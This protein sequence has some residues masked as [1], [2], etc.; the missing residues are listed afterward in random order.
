LE[1]LGTRS[2]A[3]PEQAPSGKIG[4]TRPVAVTEHPLA[5]SSARQKYADST[6]FDEVNKDVFRT[7]AEIAFFA[8]VLPGRSRPDSYWEDTQCDILKPRTHHDVLCRIL[9]LYA[10]LNPGVRYVQGMNEILAPIYYVFATDP[11]A[12][13]AAEPDSFYCFSVLMETQRDVF[14]QELDG[15]TGGVRSRMDAVAQLL[16]RKDPELHQHLVEHK[17][18]SH[19]YSFRWLML[20]FSQE[21]EL[22]E[23]LRLWDSLLSDVNKPLP[24]SYYFCCAMLIEVREALLAGDFADNVRLLSHFPPIEIQNL[25]VTAKALRSPDLVRGFGPEG[26][27]ELKRVAKTQGKQVASAVSARAQEASNHAINGLSS[28][29]S[30]AERMS[31]PERQSV[32]GKW[33]AGWA[34]ASRASATAPGL[35]RLASWPAQSG[36]DDDRKWWRRRGSPEA[37][38]T[39]LKESKDALFSVFT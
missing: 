39:T 19:Y 5:A 17:V 38:P 14:C 29:S 36:N 11:L 22:S 12:S 27:A 18:D 10:K 2:T 9:F 20:L 8:D 15:E 21:F 25:L 32:V 23:I 34:A 1:P 13:E 28:L 35:A 31:K 3:R 6:I 24:F 7:R 33:G 30:F 37:P 4:Q 16:A 26:L